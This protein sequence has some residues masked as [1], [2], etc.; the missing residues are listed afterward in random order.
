MTGQRDQPQTASD[1]RASVVIVNYNGGD[2]VTACLESV[3]ADP[4]GA[5]YQII[6]VDNAS[7]DGSAQVVAD[8]FPRLTLLRSQTNLGFGGANNLGARHARGDYLAF[9]NPDTVVTPGWLEALLA[10]LEEEPQPALATSKILLLNEPERINTAGNEVH[11]T[12]LT[13]CRGAGLDSDRLDEPA[14]VTAVSGAAFAMHRELFEQLGGFDAE[15]FMYL[16]DTDLSLRARLAGA[17]CLYVP[18]SVVYH[19]Y[20]LRFG[21]DKTYYEEH[22]R[23]RM[24]L[25]AFR[26]PTL[27]L[28]LPALLLAEVVTWGYVLLRDRPRWRNK[29]RAY[30]HLVHTWPGLRAARLQAQSLRRRPDRELLRAA[31]YRLDF[32]QTGAGLVADL[33]H[34]V[35][36]PLFF[37]ARKAMLAVIFW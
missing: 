13:L 12:G 8:R 37:V 17:R 19:D 2:Q 26:W 1:P 27:L 23:Y 10:A 28:L 36:D 14:E 25:K 35:F 32:E 21:P 20:E 33:A 31:H 18:R 11:L 22:N 6:L 4:A 3:L 16:E 34:V 5:A 24:V 30:A 15:F 9:L 29:L 7:S